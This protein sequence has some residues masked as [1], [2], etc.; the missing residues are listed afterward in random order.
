MR[1]VDSFYV[2]QVVLY[3]LDDDLAIAQDLPLEPITATTTDKKLNLEFAQLNLG[4][5]K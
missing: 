5:G 2:R 4:G 3:E 1:A